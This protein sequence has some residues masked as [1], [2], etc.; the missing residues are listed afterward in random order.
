NLAVDRDNPA[1]CVM[2]E[3]VLSQHS[4]RGG[5][6]VPSGREALGF[7]PELGRLPFSKD[8]VKTFRSRQSR[9][10]VGLLRLKGMELLRPHTLKFYGLRG[11]SIDINCTPSFL[12][13]SS[14]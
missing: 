1:L 4:T 6:G 2:L 9:G 13:S 3:R 7:E 11:G 5:A 12:A 10:T 8:R 14:S